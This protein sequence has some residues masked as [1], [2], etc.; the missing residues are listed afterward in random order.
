[1]LSVLSL[2]V[3]TFRSVISVMRVMRIMVVVSVISAT[4]DVNNIKH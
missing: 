4:V 2:G 1:M 3:M